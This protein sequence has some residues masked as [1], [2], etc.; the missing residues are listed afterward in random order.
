MFY[1]IISFQR[2]IRSHWSIE[3][4]LQ[5]IL[6]VAFRKIDQEHEMPIPMNFRIAP[7]GEYIKIL[8]INT[9]ERKIM[10]K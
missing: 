3:N 8:K 1:R 4:K 9:I 2:Y 5:W 10:G 7:D 6:N